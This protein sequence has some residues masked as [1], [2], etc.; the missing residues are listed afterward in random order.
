MDKQNKRRVSS[1]TDPVEF[2]N[3]TA[4]SRYVGLY[5]KLENVQ[6][7]LKDFAKSENLS[8]IFGPYMEDGSYK[9]AR[10]I[11]VADRPDSVHVRHILLSPNKNKITGSKPLNAADSLIK[12]IKSGTPFE[13]LALANS[14]DQGTAQLGGDLGWFPEGRMVVPFNECM[15]L[16]K[17][18]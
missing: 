7:N 6:D 13:I 14:D 16:R 10:L 4:D 9:I 15:F 1:C 3:L 2:I 11:A 5:V 8:A 12:L 18:R 17:K